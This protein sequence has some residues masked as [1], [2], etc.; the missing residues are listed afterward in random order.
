MSKKFL[1]LSIIAFVSILLVSCDKHDPSYDNVTRPVVKA[2]N[3]TIS[4][5]VT[6]YRGNVLANAVINING[7]ET[8]TDANGFYTYDLTQAGIYEISA[9]YAEKITQNATVQV[10]SVEVTHHYIQNFRLPGYAA[11]TLHTGETDKDTETIGGNELHGT[12]TITTSV[13]IEETALP[14]GESLLLVPI[15]SQN[16]GENIIKTKGGDTHTEYRVLA[17]SVLK[18]TDPDFTTMQ[19]P[20]K[21]TMNVV[22]EVQGLVD[23]KMYNRTTEKWED[24]KYD[25]FDDRIEFE[26]T[27]LTA[28][29]IFGYV[30][31]SVENSSTPITDFKPQDYWDNYSGSGTIHVDAVSY[32]R[33][34]GLN[35]DE[36]QGVDQLRAL[37]L[38]KLAQD[39]G[40]G[41]EK[42]VEETYTLNVDLPV[43]TAMSISGSQ[44]TLHVIYEMGGKSVNADIHGTVVVTPKTYNRVHTGGGNYVTY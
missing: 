30:N 16:D 38:E 43:G 8:R 3:S 36:K 33:K 5:I 41:K 26:V 13:V 20:G 42:T 19:S 4:G 37:L 17:G 44:E 18:C 35:L 22:K 21:M 1:C 7:V 10:A 32:T 31:I 34:T 25:S 28:Y 15:Y 40:L 29:A 23:L 12:I 27:A 24:I 14:E 6:D 39:Y 2:A 11:I 9:S